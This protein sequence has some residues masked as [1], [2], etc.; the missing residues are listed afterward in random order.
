MVIKCNENKTIKVTADRRLFVSNI[1]VSTNYLF[2]RVTETCSASQYKVNFDDQTSKFTRP[3]GSV[4]APLR[5][6]LKL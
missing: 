2:T 6:H 5:K 1:N 3:L 4:L